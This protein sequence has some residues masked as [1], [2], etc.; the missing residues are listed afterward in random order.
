MSRS[1]V[2]RRLA[3]WVP[4][5]GGRWLAPVAIIVIAGLIYALLDPGFGF[6]TYGL[7]VFVSLALSIAVVTYAY[8]GVQAVISSRR[9]RAPAAVKLFPIAIGIAIVCVI[10]S[11]LTGFKPGYLYGFVGGMAFL[12]TQ[13][14]D[15]RKKGRLV[16]LA[17]G[18]LLA[19]SLAAWFLAVPLTNAAEAGSSWLKILQG[20]CVGTFVAGLEGLVF[21]LVP[22]SFMDGGTL[23]R[24]N[25][26]VWGGVFGI[27]IFL[28][29]HVLLNKNSKYGAAFQQTSAKVVVGL[30]A[31]WTVVTVGTYLYFRKP[32]GRSTAR[33]AAGHDESTH[34]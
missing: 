11:R 31:F 20:I 34:T 19:V 3:S 16:L 5:A 13:Q 24:W 10:L 2:G 29:W 27:V 8:E 9:Y 30:L 6:S 18:C 26:W 4:H 28:F 21:G 15:D 23:F 1:T 14:P 25:K 32:R 7:I 12:G 33:P 17:A 22:L